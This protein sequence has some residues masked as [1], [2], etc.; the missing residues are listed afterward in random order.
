MY[1][2]KHGMRKNVDNFPLT[3]TLIQQ[4]NWSKLEIQVLTYID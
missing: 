3:L 2:Y 1:A 4:L